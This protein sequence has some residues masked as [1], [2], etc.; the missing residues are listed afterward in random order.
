MNVKDMPPQMMRVLTCF[1]VKKCTARHAHLVK[2]ILDELDL[3]GHLCTTKDGKEGSL[4]VLEDLGKVLEFLLHEEAGCPLR[5][6]DTDHGGVSSVSGT[7]AAATFSARAFAAKSYLRVVDVH[8]PKG[9][10]VL[11]EVFHALGVRY[12]QFSKTGLPPDQG[13]HQP[14]IFSSPFFPFP[15]S[16]TWNLRFSSKKT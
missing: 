5:E 11:S 14:L 1:V 3:V 12:A 4:G 13:Y 7:K 15:S 8:R 10:E 2:H 16:S 6:V 9:C